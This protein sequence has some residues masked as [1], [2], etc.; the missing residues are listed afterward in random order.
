MHVSTLEGILGADAGEPP[1]LDFSSIAPGASAFA[2]IG[3]EVEDLGIAA[4]NG[5]VADL[6]PSSRAKLAQ[7]VSVDARH[8][9]W[10]R[11][12]E[13]ARPAP[14]AVDSG[15]GSAA[16]KAAITKTGVVS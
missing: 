8:A 16:V 1:T 11:G 14:Q 15:I 3:L 13:G 4:F 6:T 7:V 9:G 12:L 2:K 5:R 10:L